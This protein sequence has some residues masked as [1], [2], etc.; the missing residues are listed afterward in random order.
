MSRRL[1][2]SLRVQLI[3]VVVAALAMAQVVSLFLFADERS[4]AIRAALG[5]EAAGRAATV[6]RLIEEA[7][8]DLH[9]SILRAANSPLVRF[10]LAPAASVQHTD[11]SDGGIV[12]ARIRTLL[13]DS[14][15]RDI[16]VELHQVEGQ[17]MPLPNLSREMTEMH[18]A[19]MQGELT[20]VEM[21]LSIA[22]S[23]GRW[24]NVGTRFER[25]PIQWPL[26]SM[27]TFAL[28][29][30]LLMLVVIWFV[31]TRLTG[32]LRRV[33][34]AADSLGRGEDV[35]EIPL[36]GP[37]EV[38]DLARSFNRMQARLTRFVS[39]RTRMLAALGHDL[40]TPLTNMRI[41]AEMVDDDETRDS[42]VAS[43][44]EMQGMVEATLTFARGLVGT[45]EPELVD[46]RHYLDDLCIA[47]PETVALLGP[48]GCELRLRPNAMR[49]ALRNLVENALRY[50][51]VA[52]LDWHVASGELVL[53]VDDDGPGIPED[54]LD[55]VFDPFFRL[56][57]SRSLETGG[58]GLGLS[59]ART[60]IQS[61]GG[62][63]SLAN[64]PE[65]GL[66]ATV[67]LPLGTPA[68]NE[69]HI[70]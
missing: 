52:R 59:I 57:R 6:V 27:M 12:E 42:I 21:N 55:K 29:A 33:S 46:L 66:R 62:E 40:R 23:G 53:T 34:R 10:D 3:L 2:L 60:I 22:L 30:G 35:A 43:V 5:F 50:G 17:L 61:H 14:Y 38:R 11:H 58:H 4:L 24:L 19:M 63:V 16:R 20:A 45:E 39:E 1:F 47:M 7:P 49:R 41:R 37:T 25:P 36:T 64:R 15:S 65:G 31:M 51:D 67:R 68:N 32:P 28:S 13:G 9:A 69:V 54:Q 18:M 26:Y 8:P 48:E 44:E 70:S 56:E